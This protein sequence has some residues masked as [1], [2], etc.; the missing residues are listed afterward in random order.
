ML[1][2]PLLAA[3][4]D[5]MTAPAY[6]ETRRDGV[7]DTLF[8]ERIADPYRWLE[9]DVRNDPEVADWVARENAVTH[10]YLD[11]LPDRA[12][13]AAK[14][15][16]LMD[17]ERF[18]IPVKAGGRY[19][20]ERNA[21]LQNQSQLFVRKGLKGKPQLLLDPAKWSADGTSALDAWKP[22]P[23]GHYLLYSVQDDG[24]D[25]R[26]LEVLD[27]R[28]GERLAD[29]VEWAKFTSLA[30]V[31]E[32]GFL[33][34]RFPEPAEGQ[35]FQALNYNQAVYFHRLG[36]SQ[37]ED[38]LVFATPD[39]PE[40]SHSAEVTHDGR[41]AVITSA[42]GT[43]ARYEIHVIDLAKRAREGWFARPLITGFDNAWNLIEGVGGVL[44]F[45]T[46]EDAPRFRVVAINL[47]TPSPRWYEIVHQTGETI[48]A[49]S[50]V[51]DRLVISYLKDAAS[52]ALIFDLKGG[53]AEEIRLNGLGTA[54]GFTGKPG[55]PETFYSFASFNRPAGIYR[56]DLATMATQAFALPKLT[57]DPDAYLVE[58]RFYTSKDGTK[59]PM[60][61]VRKRSAAEA[62]QAVPT[63]LYGY[64][65]FDISLTPGFSAVRMAWLE[66]GGAFALANIRGG[67]EYGKEWHDAGRLANKQNV[68]DDFIAAGEYLKREGITTGHGLAIEGRSNGGLL[69]GAVTNQRPDLFDAVHAAVGVMDM[70]RF[71]RWT[72]GR[73]WVDDY[74]HPDR[75]EDF[76]VLL[77]YSPYHNIHS[78]VQY[79]A[80]LVTTADTDDRVVPGHSFKYAAALQAAD[81]GGKPHLIRIETAAGHGSGKPTDKQI[82]EGADVLAFM[83]QW[84]GLDVRQAK[85]ASS[86]ADSG[87]H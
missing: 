83:A 75:E 82:A 25:W 57:F 72:A 85:P 16:E 12:W 63:M 79:P 61:V 37:A 80:I 35:D 52:R 62:G 20:Y 76:R 17:Y 41:W 64:G 67:G 3:E 55:D 68:F 69:M 10:A 22:S 58:Q 40:R 9:D 5:P 50:L 45:T 84:T 39:H 48:N 34:S 26:R 33:Y 23:G 15:G 2:H 51:G 7:V 6:P 66:A 28:K 38:E 86:P 24:S 87:S 74:G 30:W 59:V 77:S 11:S 18:S 31:G 4:T 44:W 70:L 47:D 43:D 78:G 42:V 81:I 32:E 8:G 36:T 21:G 65:G 49:A 56:M 1:A 19:F 29:T 13:F 14:I 73:Y 60:F 71:D 53:R 54:S 46:N 27:V